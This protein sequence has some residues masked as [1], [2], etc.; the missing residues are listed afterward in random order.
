[1]PLL[2]LAPAA[3]GKVQA[4]T[5]ESCPKRERKFK[6]VKAT[7]AVELHC[8]RGVQSPEQQQGQYSSFS[9]HQAWNGTEDSE[10]GFSEAIEEEAI[11]NNHW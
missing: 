8:S 7:G 6:L 2:H 3:F 5:L 9:F 10:Q 4:P 11:N 1:M